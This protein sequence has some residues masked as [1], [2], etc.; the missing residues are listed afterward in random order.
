M[1]RLHPGIAACVAGMLAVAGP[2]RAEICDTGWDGDKLALSIAG[3]LDDDL[4][5]I[6]G[7]TLEPVELKAGQIWAFFE[8][9]YRLSRALEFGPTLVVCDGE[10]PNAFAISGERQRIIGVTVGM[11]RLL[12]GDVG[13]AAAVVG[14]EFAHHTLGHH[15][16]SQSRDTAIGIAALIAG[17]LLDVASRGQ[18]GALAGQGTRLANVAGSLVSRS[19]DRDQERAADEEG[20]KHMIA[21]GFDP[22]GALDL[23]ERMSGEEGGAFGAFLATHPGW[24][25]RAERLRVLVAAWTQ[26]QEANDSA[27]SN[28]DVRKSFDAGMSAW[29]ADDLA[30][31]A[32]ELGI[33]AAAGHAPA[34]AALAEFYVEGLGGL[35]QDEVEAV[36]LYGLA[37]RQGHVVGEASYG[38]AH[39]HGRGGLAQDDVE[40]VRWFRRAVQKGDAYSMVQLGVLYW[41]GT[42]RIPRDATEAARLFSMSAG[43]GHPLGQANLGAMYLMGLGGLERDEQEALRL[44]R[45]AAEQGNTVGQVNLAEMYERGTAG[46]PKDAG[47]AAYWYQQAAA[48]GDGVARAALARLAR[49]GAKAATEA[50]R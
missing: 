44:T 12:D 26:A 15:A 50:G 11:L 18:A 35:P 48:Q 13:M 31:A 27:R 17:I 46:L 41:R 37:A 38:L 10:Q 34:Q 45:L 30:A 16:E 25:E 7:D 29:Q 1:Q 19:F 32:R 4:V 24:D 14:H 43:L 3:R 36:K 21:A 33:A 8:A 22:Q 42:P 40:A 9:K 49:Q 5:S 23:A 6:A 47:L 39:L 28:D 20:L 2:A